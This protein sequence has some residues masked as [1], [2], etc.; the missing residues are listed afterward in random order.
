MLINDSI[1]MRLKDYYALIP[2]LP[3]GDIVLLHKQLYVLIL[4]NV[5]TKACNY[6]YFYVLTKR[7]VFQELTR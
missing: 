7:F 3:N 5:E 6:G 1:M 2:F 4:T